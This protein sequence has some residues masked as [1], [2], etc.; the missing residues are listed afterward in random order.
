MIMIGP[1]YRKVRGWGEA[2]SLSLTEPAHVVYELVVAL[3]RVITG[4]EKAELSGPV[5]IV[6]ETAKAVRNGPAE[7]L[8]L[9]GMLSAYLGGFNL[10][11]V[12]ALDGGRLI[13]LSYEAIARRK[14]DAKMEAK[15]HAVGLLM[16]LTL[17]AAVTWTEIFPKH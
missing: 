8:M 13:F 14:A 4:R 10:L 17:V 2:T 6:R 12:P 5:G 1:E 3:G 9:L 16:M 15:V 7:A 11:P